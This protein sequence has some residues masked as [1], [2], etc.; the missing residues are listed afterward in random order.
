M[1]YFVRTDGE[2]I[3]HESFTTIKYNKLLIRKD[4]EPVYAYIN[5]II[6]LYNELIISREK[7][8]VLLDDDTILCDNFDKL[9]NDAIEENS[10][11]IITFHS[12]G[13]TSH[14]TELWYKF[15]SPHVK[16][17]YYPTKLL[18]VL[19]QILYEQSMIHGITL[20]HVGLFV[21]RA[22][23]CLTGADSRYAH[24]EYRPSL[25]QC[26]NEPTKYFIDYFKKLNINYNTWVKNI[27]INDYT[28][29]VMTET[30]LE[31][32]LNIDKENWKKEA[33]I[34]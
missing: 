1:I 15:E 31:R 11:R 3:L 26:Y 30:K 14:L 2:H 18:P 8:A 27:K 10:D 28:Y 23:D 4:I 21:T 12:C 7:G 34:C 6:E 20:K 5:N 17:V 29:L 13:Y 9:V 32:L 25:V 19:I 33:K 22:L 16:C 24:I